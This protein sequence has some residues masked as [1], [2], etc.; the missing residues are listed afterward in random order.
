MAGVS[1]IKQVDITRTLNFPRR[2]V[3]E[4]WTD[5][6]H[7]KQWFAPP[8]CTIEFKK[9]DIKPGGTFHSCVHDPA[10]GDCWCI[11]EYLEIIKPE[12]IVY[13]VINADKDGNPVDPSILGMDPEWPAKSVV[14][15]LFTEVNGKTT[16]NL[17]QTASEE[18]AKRTGAYPS[19]IKMLD[20]LD[21]LLVGKQSI[22]N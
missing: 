14:T 5:P 20:R 19:W 13:S 10:H 3:F 2:I 4:A 6:K 21:D 11:G 12:K 1:K 9:L 7:L 8:G 22:I 15:I 18:V 16:I 17:R